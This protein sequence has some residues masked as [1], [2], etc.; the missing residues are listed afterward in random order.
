MT[1]S[2]QLITSLA[3]AAICVRLGVPRHDEARMHAI[4]CELLTAYRDAIRA[5][6]LTEW[7]SPVERP[8]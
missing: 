1:E 3:A 4:V 5:S 8:R 6:I 7:K 2:D